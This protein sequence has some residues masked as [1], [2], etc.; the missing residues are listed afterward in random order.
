MKFCGKTCTA[1]FQSEV[2]L[3]TLQKTASAQPAFG[4]E[5]ANDSKTFQTIGNMVCSNSGNLWR[6]GRMPAA[7]IVL[8][9][10]FTRSPPSFSESYDILIF[11]T[12]VSELWQS[13]GPLCG[14]QSIMF[15]Q[16]P[17]GEVGGR[18]RNEINNVNLNIEG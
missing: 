16:L 9:T 11:I 6:T 7:T 3:V 12:T 18:A 2:I 13:D 1:F 5:V 4:S 15:P 17:V 14:F 8:K 10:R